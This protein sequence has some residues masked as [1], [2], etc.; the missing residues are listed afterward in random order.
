MINSSE[1]KPQGETIPGLP[2]DL[3][4]V[5]RYFL[6][7]VKYTEFAIGYKEEDKRKIEEDPTEEELDIEEEAKIWGMSKQEVAAE[8]EQRLNPENLQEEI[9]G[10][11][12]ERKYYVDLLDGLKKGEFKACLDYLRKSLEAKELAQSLITFESTSPQ[13]REKSLAETRALREYI[14]LLESKAK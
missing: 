4:L 13:Y 2:Q 11:R 7:K 12:N 6:S 14:N 3:Q 9:D 8:K 1:P 5:G 10:L